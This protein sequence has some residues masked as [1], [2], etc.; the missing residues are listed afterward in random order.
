MSRERYVPTYPLDE[1]KRIAESGRII[2]LSRPRSFVLNHECGEAELVVQDL[3]CSLEECDFKKS[4]ELDIRP[5]MWADVYGDVPYVNPYG[6]EPHDW[7]VKFCVTEEAVSVTVLS[8]NYEGV[9]H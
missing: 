9:T 2:L 6:G 7:Y 8:A 4:V 1:V 5:G 3:L